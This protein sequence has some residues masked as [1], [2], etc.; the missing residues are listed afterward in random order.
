M[1]GE[2]GVRIMWASAS[3]RHLMPSLVASGIM[4]RTTLNIDS[5]VLGEVRR[6]AD[7]QGKSLAQVVSELLAKA[8]SSRSRSSTRGLAWSVKPMGTRVDFED[9]EAVRRALENR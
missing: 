8:L 7:E 5:S 9:K 6:L 3:A 2:M 4:P 1:T